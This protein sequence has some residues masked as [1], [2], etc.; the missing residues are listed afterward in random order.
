MIVCTWLALALSMP[1]G[2]ADPSEPPIVLQATIDQFDPSG[3]ADQTAPGARRGVRTEHFDEAGRMIRWEQRNAAGVL[4]LSWVGV[5]FDDHMVPDRAAYWTEG[6]AAPTAEFGVTTPDGR[7]QDVLYGSP[8]EKPRRQLRQYFDAAHRIVYQEYFAPRSQ[9]RYSEEIYRYDDADNELGRT[10][11]RLDG[12]AQL[13]T[14]YEIDATDP[15]GR[16]TRRRVFRN[17]ELDRIETR[18][19]TLG[20]AGRPSP[21]ASAGP[22]PSAAKILPIPFAAGTVSVGATGESSPSFS[23]DGRRLFFTR[24]EDDWT[25]QTGMISRRRNGVWLEPEPAPFGAAMYNGAFI[26]DVTFLFCTR[27]GD[28]GRGR[29]FVVERT[30]EQSEDVWGT[31]RDLTAETGFVGG[32]FCRGPGDLVYFHRDGDLHRA[33]WRDG[34]V[35]DEKRLPSPINTVDGVEFGACVSAE[36]TRLIFTRS[37]EPGEGS[38]VFTAFRTEAGWSTPRRLPIPYG[39]GATVSPD[40]EDLVYV[41]EGD[42]VRIPLVLLP[43]LTADAR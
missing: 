39:W 24:Y 43:D 41:V 13:V 23:P 18:R 11:R 33:R 40:G 14:R 30:D 5:Y 20:S 37:V 32:Y 36:G 3:D 9:R 1:G 31:P 15:F 42:V 29:A 2:A 35:A 16:W 21:P 12:Q 6:A 38:G 8:G 34:L 26:D 10:W 25:R 28:G 22:I 17:D 4:T 27:G 7:M 19:L